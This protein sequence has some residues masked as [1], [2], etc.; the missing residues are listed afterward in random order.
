MRELE[1]VRERHFFRHASWH[2]YMCAHACQRIVCKRRNLIGR[3]TVADET[4]WT[5]GSLSSC[6]WGF[7]GLSLRGEIQ[8]PPP[9]RWRCLDSLA[10]DWRGC[11]TL[12]ITQ[13]LRVCWESGVWSVARR[14]STQAECGTAE[15]CQCVCQS[16][17]L[18]SV[19][20]L[21]VSYNTLLQKTSMWTWMLYSGIDLVQPVCMQI[22][23]LL[24][25]VV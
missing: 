6:W 1:C 3:T 21:P 7:G 12:Q 2:V 19:Y 5:A 18:Y 15:S 20:N 9:A 23:H 8:F 13:S 4:W 10:Q 22:R 14:D 17:L 16:F 24:T 25:S 11:V